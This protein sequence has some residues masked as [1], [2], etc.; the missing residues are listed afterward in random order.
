MLE[1]KHL[2]KTYDAR[3][4]QANTVLH[5]ITLSLP[6]KGFVCIVGA[7]GCG[8]TTLLNAAGGLDT[9]DSG[10]ITIDNSTITKCG[11]RSSETVRCE[12]FGYIFQNYHLLADRS[13]LYNLYIAMHSLALTHR[14]KI[15]RARSVLRTVGMERYEKRIVRELS[16]GQQ[17]R[18]SIARALALRPRVIFADE[19]TGNL[20][21]ANTV[22]I[23]TLLRRVSRT[24]LVVMVTHEEKTARFFADRIIRIADGR[25]VE[26]LSGWNRE[27]YAALG[28]DRI[29][30]GDC[31][32]EIAEAEG[33]SV[34]LLRAPGAA[35]VTLTVAAL[36]NRI[37]IKL[38]DRRIVS[39]G[40]TSELPEILEGSP[41]SLSAEHLDTEGG[42]E[43]VSPV[44]RTRPGTG[45]GAKMISAE[46]RRLLR[47]G[48]AKKTVTRI[49]LFLITA[50]TVFSLA[51]FLSVA[52]LDPHDFI[53]TDPHLL[54]ITIQRNAG[55]GEDPDELL[56]AADAAIA[57][58]R[59]N[60]PDC[61]VYPYI[62]TQLSY[63]EQT[64]PQ[65]NASYV[66]FS[67]YSY[68]PL[69]KLDS[70]KLIAGRMPE[71]SYEIV[72]DRW[73]L[74]KLLGTSGIVQ[75]GIGS[76]D[77][78]LGKSLRITRQSYMPQIVGICDCASPAVYLNETGM[79]GAFIRPLDVLSLSELKRLYPGTYDDVT[80]SSG[81]VIVFPVFAGRSYAARVGKNI[82]LN[83]RF[84]ATIKESWEESPNRK[85]VCALADEDIPR[86]LDSLLG[87]EFTV[88]CE[89]KDAMLFFL[90]EGIPELEGIAKLKIT[91]S[92]TEA[93][94]EQREAAL[95]RVG[96]RLI[97][98]STIT[99]VSVVLLCLLLQAT[100]RER[101]G[102]IA[103]CRLLCLPRRKL[104]AVFALEA[105]S[106]SLL[107]SLPA[108]ALTYGTITLLS[109]LPS[110]GYAVSM[111]WYAALAAYLCILFI[112][113]CASLLPVLRISRL[114]AARI[115]A[116]YEP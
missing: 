105:L 31:T 93:W 41:P 116:K 49:F 85:T 109:S 84:L 17:Q 101:I 79:L 36:P 9:F 71:N 53:T 57:Y 76:I 3:S 68:L 55:M 90:S 16:G 27:D 64:F 58:I 5:D 80:L 104:L 97:V 28:G 11:T 67:G 88:W 40:S 2:T 12:N 39:T 66:S 83:S 46:A 98:T 102:M 62:T 81:E 42:I 95:A 10:T 54:R 77:Y 47:S 23:C 14:E 113:F 111:P 61:T 73:V 56:T 92:Y 60:G 94:Q 7:S 20:D 1:I 96:T 107:C 25:I 8:K 70:T 29:Y 74:D 72:V 22:N 82:A 75:N 4:A 35:P 69:E 110:I 86:A 108:A 37:V 24:S 43:P 78:F 115:A 103:V 89:D 65:V 32:E 21:E 30:A 50:L 99:V 87:S 100:V 19:P 91:D 106:L 34:R 51:D 33:F 112:Q 44:R 59:E 26:D 13:V 38:N 18:V 48:G 63:T 52:Q 6:D 114:P 45:F 15:S